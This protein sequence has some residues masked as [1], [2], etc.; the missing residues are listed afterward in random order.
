ML[1]QVKNLA[2]SFSTYRGKVKAVARC[3]FFGR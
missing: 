2:V 1:L 3:K